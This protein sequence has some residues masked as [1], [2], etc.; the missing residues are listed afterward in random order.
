[1]G[2]SSYSSLTT[3]RVI[4][5]RLTATPSWQLPHIVPYL[6]SNIPSCAQVLQN[7]PIL[8]HTNDGSEI[9]VVIHKFKTQ[10]S[11]LLAEKSPQARWSAVVLIKATVE[12]GGLEVLRASGAWIRGLLGILQRPDP[13]ITKELSIITL[14][15]IFLLAQDHQSIVREIITPSMTHFIT[16]CLNILKARPSGGEK[17]TSNG[18]YSLPHTVI[19]ALCELIPSYPSLFRPFVAQM[20]LLVQPLIAATHSDLGMSREKSPDSNTSSIAEH[21]R[22]L[23]VLLNACAPK[24]LSGDEWT[25][26]VQDVIKSSHRTADLVFRAVMEDWESSSTRIRSE[27]ITTRV[28][29]EPIC[30]MESDELGLPG[31]KG[32]CAGTERLDGL[33]RTIQTFLTGSTPSNVNLPISS[34]LDVVTRVLSVKAPLAENGNAARGGLRANSEIGRDEREGLLFSLPNVH[35]LALGILSTLISRLGYISASFCQGALIQALWL[36]ENEFA[37]SDIRKMTYELTAEILALVGLSLSKSTAPLVSK[38]AEK[39]CEDLMLPMRSSCGVLDSTQSSRKIAANGTA[40]LSADSYIKSP[41]TATEDLAVPNS[42]QLSASKLLPF[43]LTHVPQDFFAFSMRAEIDRVAILTRNK[44]AMLASVLNPPSKPKSGPEMSSSLV[45]L[46]REFPDTLEVDALLRPRLPVLQRKRDNEDGDYDTYGEGMLGGEDG[47]SGRE[48]ESPA[49]KAHAIQVGKDSLSSEHIQFPTEISEQNVEH[50][51]TAEPALG[52]LSLPISRGQEY[53][54][55]SPPTKHYLN[56][57]P[58]SS[59]IFPKEASHAATP[60]PDTDSQRPKRLRLQPD[61]AAS[62][63]TAMAALG[64]H[65]SGRQTQGRSFQEA[66]QPSSLINPA[67]IEEGE[68]I[69]SDDSGIPLIDTGMD[70]DEDEKEDD[71]Q[72]H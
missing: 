41:T 35:V 52:R 5:Q 33:L 1:M 17:R 16:S 45:F 56:N 47:T 2:A 54:R 70:T 34:I 66:Q 51:V 15:R 50:D 71:D 68:E 63:N 25:R 28:F 43:L 42:I 60:Q 21:S 30:D 29:S 61:E 38:C 31:W 36:F 27:S 3:L 57:E 9:A 55:K 10:I 23:F 69:E 14:T 12:T 26:S 24:K 20:R 46:A 53:Q 4:T 18:H 67:R 58:V 44:K 6:A 39:C 72:I 59:T 65:S 40:T 64:N 48:S 7:P 62:T 22:K 11:T 8:G 13:A 19:Q 37:N 49:H 32:I